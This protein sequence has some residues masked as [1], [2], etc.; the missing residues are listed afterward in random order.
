MS[1]A[2][3]DFEEEEEDPDDEVAAFL[4]IFLPIDRDYESKYLYHFVDKRCRFKRRTLQE[5]VYSFLE[6]PVGWHC[7]AY[8]ATV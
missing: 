2:S 5:K 6:H 8:H 3:V 7:L 4:P 1:C